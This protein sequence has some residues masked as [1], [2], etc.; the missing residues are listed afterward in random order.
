MTAVSSRGGANAR[1]SDTSLSCCE[2][3]L[4]SKMYW[5]KVSGE[6]GY[7][8]VEIQDRELGRVFLRPTCRTSSS[9]TWRS[10][11]LILLCSATPG[12]RPSVG[13]LPR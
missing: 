12:C 9:E 11:P 7:W 6:A 4:G 1:W 13:H 8:Q 5:F 3:K 10:T 2:D